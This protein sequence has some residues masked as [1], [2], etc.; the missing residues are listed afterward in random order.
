MEI[1]ETK[2]VF[3]VAS[4]LLKISFSFIEKS[5][6]NHKTI[7]DDI[8]CAIFFVNIIMLF[9]I[10]LVCIFYSLFPANY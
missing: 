9:C 2:V 5:Y 3:I 1:T 10:I 4:I 7:E 6:E 8:I